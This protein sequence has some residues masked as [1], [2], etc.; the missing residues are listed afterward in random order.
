MDKKT[1]GFDVMETLLSYLQKITKHTTF[2]VGFIIIFYFYYLRNRSSTTTNVASSQYSYSRMIILGV[3]LVFFRKDIM[4]IINR[5]SEKGK[6]NTNI[7][8][9]NPIYEYGT[10]LFEA[11]VKSSTLE[12]K[13]Q[14]I[15]KQI[16]K[17]KKT[18]PE[19][20]KD[21][22]YHLQ[23]FQ[24][25][26]KTL[27]NK[28]TF[29][30]QHID[31]LNDRKDEILKLVD[32]LEYTENT[33]LSRLKKETNDFLIKALKEVKLKVK[34]NRINATCSTIHITDDVYGIE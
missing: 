11:N 18:S 23:Y 5:L 9:K 25:E 13:P 8:N 6:H 7:K 14:K 17:F 32:S 27:V 3:L 33:D 30:Y 21:I 34:D 10:Q 22:Y 16:K 24:H 20:V 15:W 31:K 4:K 28:N 12:G 1:K 29:L 26:I 19:L 2:L